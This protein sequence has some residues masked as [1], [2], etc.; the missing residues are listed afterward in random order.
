M[1]FPLSTNERQ[2][3]SGPTDEAKKLM[4]GHS[5][6]AF[7]SSHAHHCGVLGSYCAVSIDCSLVLSI[8]VLL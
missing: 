2:A 7:Y 3:D 6:L 8:A 4:P 1:R 5:E